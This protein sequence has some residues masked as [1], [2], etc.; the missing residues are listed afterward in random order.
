V[1]ASAPPAASP[2]L[3]VAWLGVLAGLMAALFAPN[4]VRAA[5]RDPYA[6]LDRM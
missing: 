1:I 2:P 3:R 5:E 6:L 4:P